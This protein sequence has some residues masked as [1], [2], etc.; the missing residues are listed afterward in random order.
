MDEDQN[1]QT[2]V[3]G[4][5]DQQDQNAGT[6]TENTDHGTETTTGDGGA[7]GETEAPE[8]EEP[9]QTW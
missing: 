4:G 9:K 5:E 3:E 2:P 1:T 7:T 8:D 6:P